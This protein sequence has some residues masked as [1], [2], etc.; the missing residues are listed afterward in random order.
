MCSNEILF[1]KASSEARGPQLSWGRLSLG[2]LL[3]QVFYNF[4]ATENI[5]QL[6]W[7]KGLSI[8]DLLSQVEGKNRLRN[9]TL[10]LQLVKNGNGSREGQFGVVQAKDAIKRYTLKPIFRQAQTER[11]VSTYKVPNLWERKVFPL[12]NMRSGARAGLG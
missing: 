3:Q 7:R 10:I 8:S 4:R 12:T 2:I 9:S 6:I 1:I 5:L 11:L